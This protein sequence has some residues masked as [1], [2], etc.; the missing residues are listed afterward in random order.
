MNS[1]AADLLFQVD[2]LQVALGISLSGLLVELNA[3]NGAQ[4]VDSSLDVV[5]K[6]ATFKDIAAFLCKDPTTNTKVV[7]SRRLSD[8]YH[9]VTLYNPKNFC[10]HRYHCKK[11]KRLWK[12]HS[13]RC[14]M[15]IL[16]GQPFNKRALSSLLHR[17]FSKSL[18]VWLQVGQDVH[19]T[20]QRMIFPQAFVFLQ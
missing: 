9:K 15:H 4:V 14:Q 3:Q 6:G 10:V 7:R 11:N 2:S 20:P 19:L 18:Q 16:S 17:S 1:E 12:N 8:W 5:G 13:L